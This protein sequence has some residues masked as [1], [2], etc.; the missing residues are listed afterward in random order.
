M[1][2]PANL[3]SFSQLTKVIARGTGEML[4]AGESEDQFLGKLQHKGVQVHARAADE[5][6]KNS[7]RPTALH[8]DLLRLFSK[9]ESVRVVTTNFDLLFEDAAEE[10]FDCQPDLFA[11][12]ALPL[13]SGFDGIVHVHGALDRDEDMVLTDSDF[14]RAYLIEGWARR[15]LVDLFRSYTVLFIGYSHNDTVMNYLAR[16]LPADTARFA[17]TA[18]GDGNR[19]QILGIEPVPYQ[20]AQNG[21][22]SALYEGVAGLAEY[23]N[24]GILDWQREIT[25]IARAL[26]PIDDEATDLIHYALSDP[27]RTRFFTSAASHPDWIGWLE[28]K[29]H[30]DNLFKGGPDGLSEQ[31]VQLAN[32]LADKFAAP[33]AND[34]FH[35]IARHDVKMHPDFWFALGRAIGFHKDKPIEPRDLAR[36]VSILLATAPPYPWI[37]P[38]KFILPALGERCA[39]A[40]L[41]D[42]LLEIFTKMA[43]GRLSLRSSQLPVSNSGTGYESFLFPDSELDV[44][45]HELNE[46]WRLRLKPRLDEVAEALLAIVVQNLES[47]HRTLGG[48][49]EADRSWSAVSF[50]RSAI[51]PHEQD[52][53]PNA[54]NVIID[55]GRD[56]LEY[57]TSTQ[58]AV[59]SNWC[60]RLIRQ[61]MPILRRLAVHMLSERKDLT[62]DEKI[63]WLLSKIGLHDVATHHET[64]QAVRIIYPCANSEGRKAVIKAVLSFKDPITEDEDSARFTARHQFDWLHWLHQSDRDCQ[65]ATQ[66]MEDVRKRHPDFQPGAH[67]DLA[68]YTTSVTFEE[69]QPPW[70]VSDLLSRPNKE[71]LG[72][73]SSFQGKDFLGPNR[74]GLLRAVEEAATQEFEWGIDLADALAESGN[75]DADLWPPLMQAWSRELSAEKHRLVLDRLSNA[76]LYA[77]HARPVADALRAF[78]T[79]DGPPYAAELLA[80][81]NAVAA[82]LWN[83]LDLRQPMYEERD[84]MFRAINHPAGVLAEFW[85]RSLVLWRKQQDPP[86]TSL[87]HQYK[88]VLSA[89]AQ[90]ATSADTLGKAFLASQLP[91]IMAADEDWAKQYMVPLF[92]SEN[93]ETRQ[94]VWQG[95]LYGHL[96]PQIADCMKDAF[97]SVTSSMTDL[98]SDEGEARRQFVTMY[99]WMVA[100]F[101]DQPLEV[102]IPRFFENAEPQDK[103]R[104]AWELGIQLHRMDNERQNEWWERWLKRY[105]EGRLQGVPM[106]LDAGEVEVILERVIHLDTLFPDAVELAIQMPKTPLKG[107]HVIHE[108]NSSD[109]GSKY[110]ESTAQLLVYLADLKLPDWAWDSGGELISDLL[111]RDLPNDL[112]TKLREIAARFGLSGQDA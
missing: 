18:D 28:Q 30:L 69:P 73:L 17:L 3:P 100:Y 54:M 22:H 39:A 81:A 94:A 23:V 29:G 110:P 1:G 21:D 63:D 79:D 71:W 44:G 68:V 65:W 109:L 112:K 50:S 62:A 35:L 7:P 34:L 36:W 14:G 52:R 70:S 66:A 25:A 72:E 67:P 51:E 5:L 43:A 98:F 24:R 75:W 74:A 76:K 45:Y 107:N 64:F 85:L 4:S 101:V 38:I 46:F 20:Q 33:R 90:D 95:F 2:E 108:L 10:V 8:H 88:E 84:W 78:V 59:V 41:T 87:G 97:L 40:G 49:Q 37:G 42:S 16:A 96:T 6:S 56:C 111:T 48:W 19:W 93:A 105:W 11:A 104:F 27:T 83:C 91:F 58:P 82:A 12:P 31:E 99:A 102:W 53:L 60:D 89:I 26:P 80:E 86:P 92:D 13:G 47:Q 15:F 103:E 32:W 57:L 77:T 61:D 106:P 9:P 55:V